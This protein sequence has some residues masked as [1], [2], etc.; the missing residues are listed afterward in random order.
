MIMLQMTSL[1]T[2]S[3]PR[4]KTKGRTQ[5]ACCSQVLWMRTQLTDYGFYFDK[6]PMYYDS[7]AA[8]AIS[9]NPVQHSYTKHID[10]ADL[11]TKAL[12]E[13]RFKYL[14]RRLEHPSDTKVFTMKMEILLEPTSNKLLVAIAISC[15]PVQHSRTKHIDVCYHFIKEKVEK[16]IVELF[17]VRTEYQ[18]A[19]LFTKALPVERLT[20]SSPDDDKKRNLSVSETVASPIIPK[21]FV[22]FVKVSDSQS[23]SKIDQTETP[24]KS[25][26]KYVEQYRKTNKKPNVRGNQRN[27]NN[28]K[29][30]QLEKRVKRET[31]RSQ[32]N[33]S[34][35][36]TH[37]PIV[38]IPHKPPMRP[39]RSNM[40]GVRPNRTSFNKPTHSYTNISFQ[41]KTALRSQY[42]ASWVPTVNRNFPPINRKFFTGS[43]KFPTGNRK[44]PTA[45]I[46]F[47]TG[48]TKFS[49]ADMGMKGKAD[50]GCS[51]H[52][53][54]NISYLSDYEPFDGGY[55]SFGQG[56]CKIT[57]KGTIKTGK[58]KFENVYFVKDLKMYCVGKR[59]KL[60]DDANVLLRTLR[61]HN[62]YSIDLNNIVP[63]K[64]LTCL[65]D[66]AFADECMKWHRRLGHLNFKTMNKLVRH[67]LVR[68]LPTK[69]FENGHN[70]TACL[71]GKQHKASFH[72][73][74]HHHQSLSPPPSLPP[75]S[76]Q[77]TTGHAGIK[78]L[79][80][81]TTAQVYI[82]VVKLK[83]MLFTHTNDLRLDKAEGTTCLPN[84]AI[85]EKLARMGAK[86]TGTNSA[87]L[88]HLQSFAW[89]IIKNSYF[90][91]TFL[92]IWAI[93]PLFE[94]IMVQA[95]KEVG[96]MPTDTQDTPILVKPSSSQPQRK[97]KSRRKQRKKT[98]VPHTE[99]QPKEHIPTPSHDLLHSAGENVEY[100]ATVAEKEVRAATDEVVTTAESVEDLFGVNDLDGDEVIVDVTTGENVEFDATVAEK[101]VS[102]ATDEVVTTA[103]SVEE[104]TIQE[105]SEFRTTSPS[106]PS[107]PPQAKDKGK[108]IMVEPK[109]P[110]KNKDQIALDEEVARKLDAEMKA[111]MD[112]EERIAREK[113]EANR[114]VIEE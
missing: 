106:Q 7:K 1:S 35:I 83:L 9:C 56:G 63:H 107:Q 59:F 2:Y 68:G 12:P 80:G 105:P 60:L 55:V 43:R 53:T 103:K 64:D 3:V 36:P 66:K 8:T 86:T 104:V 38:H 108:G 49:T 101:E 4:Y 102:A 90:P 34:K 74:Y 65:V 62:M 73:R 58:L 72:H 27:W 88:W 69:C 75:P 18:L 96:E 54:G 37:R 77:S 32:N 61:H 33:T 13:E 40:N 10:L 51:R 95:P 84:T 50:S 20:E 112:K 11:F 26:V 30:H 113:N 42:R 100:D 111:K 19:D 28:L 31:T 47:P 98:E 110:L 15:N 79:H 52:M 22:K 6:I 93:T 45:S 82:S 57:G 48:S 76:L 41:R 46:K 81:V 99:P 23:K 14:V 109:K 70:C 71:K 85:F 5:S 21:P 16:G 89:P 97:H 87:A 39:M 29:S 114:V 92:I 24:K 78:G 17:F 91:S 67:N 94:T 25:P 44:F